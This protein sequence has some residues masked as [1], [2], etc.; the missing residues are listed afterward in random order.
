MKQE[1]NK[2]RAT[3]KGKKKHDTRNDPQG[4]LKHGTRNHETRNNTQTRN[5]HE[6]NEETHKQGKRNN[7]Q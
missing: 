6:R 5:R 2:Q 7:K 3:Y 4:T 1:T